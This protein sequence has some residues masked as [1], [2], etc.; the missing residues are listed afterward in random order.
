MSAINIYQIYY[1][2]QTREQLDPSF[3][4][5]DNTR[6]ERPEWYEFWVIKH[7][8]EHNELADDA[9]YGFVS[10]RFYE[11]TGVVGEQLKQL[12]SPHLAST[13]V[14]LVST[15]AWSQLAY[16]KNP[17][18]QGDYW[19]QG[20]LALSQEVLDRLNIRIDLREMISTSHDFTFCNYIVARK[21]YWQAWKQ[22][23]DAFFE[24]VEHD[25]TALGERLRGHTLYRHGDAAIRTFIQERLP[26]V[27]LQRHAFRTSAVESVEHFAIEANVFSFQTTFERAILQTCHYL[28][29]LY[30]QDENPQHLESF[31]HVRSLLQLRRPLPAQPST[32]CSGVDNN[33]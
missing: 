28:K 11:K 7:F 18:E 2:E 13:D 23:A 16:F 4:P 1:N 24:L 30:Q 14:F 27:L 12:I 10:P 25:T 22:L 17:F 32:G 9:F 26:A 3:I 20:L 21:S 31:L 33:N 8:L 5:L 29:V 19:H 15:G 6:N